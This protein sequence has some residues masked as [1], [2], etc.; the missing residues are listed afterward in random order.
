MRI[1][2]LF[3]AIMQFLNFMPPQQKPAITIAQNAVQITFPKTAAFSV[4]MTSKEKI[5]DVELIYGTDE[6]TCSDVQALVVPEF[7]PGKSVRVSWKWEME[8]S[9][10]IAPG[11]EIWWQWK[12]T[13]EK[14]ETV[15]SEKKTIIWLDKIH[16]WK[17]KE[18][19]NIRIHYYQIT[20]QLA[21]EFLKTALDAQEKLK[22][23][24]G[25]ETTDTVDL[26]MY[27]TNKEMRDSMLYEQEWTGGMAF[28]DSQKIVI[29]I[30]EKNLDWTKT[31]EAHELTHVLVGNYTF[32]CLWTTPTW[33]EEGLAVYAEGEA[34]DSTK[35]EFDKAK[36]N[37][38]LIS[39]HILSASFSSDS[40][41]VGLSYSQSFYMVKYLIDTY[42]RDKINNLLKTLSEGT[43]VDD[44]MKK[45]YGFDLNGFEKEWRK[46]INVPE[47]KW[48]AD[49]EKPTPVPT[50]IPTMQPI[51]NSQ[52][53]AQAT[54][55]AADET[56][57]PT[58]TAEASL[59]IA[60]GS[61]GSGTGT[62]IS[63]DSSN[64]PSSQ[65]PNMAPTILAI[66]GSL[67]ACLVTFI[68]TRSRNRRS[69]VVLT[70]AVLVFASVVMGA[71]PAKASPLT[72]AP[73][74]Y[75]QLPTATLYTPPPAEKGVYLNTTRGISLE[76]PK[77]ARIDTSR[78]SSNYLF[79]IDLS[80]NSVIGHLFVNPLRTGKSLQ[81]MATDIR[82]TE[83]D[84]LI[85]IKHLEDKE[86]EMD[87]GTKGWLMVSEARNPEAIQKL[88]IS[89][90]TVRGF[91]STITLMLFSSRD[92]YDYFQDVI[93]SLN[94]SIKVIAPVINGY[95]RDELLIVD[96]S[97][98]DN[99]AE[100]DPATSRG[101]SGFSNVF[102][103]LVTYDTNLN[104]KP[105][106]AES[107][108]I[109]EDGLV[110]TFHLHPEAVFHNKRPVTADDIVYSW[111]RAANAKT[112][113]ETV[114]TYLGDIQGIKDMHE[115]N[116]EH[117]SGL[118]VIDEHTLEVT[119]DKP[120]PYFLLK[121]TYPT[122]FV[123]DKENVEKSKTWYRLPNGTGPFRLIRWDARQAIY[124]E[125]FE[126]FYG[127]KPK[128]RAIL[129]LLYQGT[130]MQ[131]YEGGVTDYTYIAYDDL[132]RFKDS[133]E[134]MHDQLQSNTNMCTGYI[135]IDV[136]QPPFDDVKVRQAFAMTVD[137]EK[138]INVVT[139]NAVLPAKGLYPPAL[140]GYNK[141][142]KGLE[143]NPEK[144]RALLQE[145]KYGNELPP[146]TFSV[147]GYGNS[148]GE[149]VSALAQMWRE[150]LGVTITV[151]NIDPEYYLDVLD[152]GKHG[153]LISEGWCADYPDPENFADV[154]FHSDNEMNRG[155]YS[156]PELD[157]LL[158]DARVEKDTAKRIQM[159]QQAEEIIINDS[160]VIF[161][162]HSNSYALVKPYLQGFVGT[163]IDVPL[164]RYMWIDAEKFTK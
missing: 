55:P 45:V 14:G 83:L 120:V 158:E 118:K 82:N 97:E 89:F 128:L 17:V 24:T 25:M 105:D 78:A 110:Y 3:A 72:A 77:I 103:G 62:G 139:D 75:P 71:T 164:E 140:P 76:I 123:V 18:D 136:T 88:K 33:L 2:M 30:D 98:T 159:Y 6:R 151:Q 133:S 38:D 127:D 81:E 49:A 4:S 9:G 138:Y 1:L 93:E 148:V 43:T 52:D 114:M 59:P 112:K 37:N 63:L 57:L 60:I 113:S 7:T 92:T 20:D 23:D 94:T 29:G 101:S 67:M 53:A 150:N 36:E 162:T 102:S 51:S 13:N 146:I 104:I 131:L 42:G 143:F 117:I 145:S 68:L 69:G 134:P 58:G 80:N 142:S 152:S 126:E 100:N 64:G 27:K 8:D 66:L 48:A 15:T 129:T 44:A 86:V 157:K 90:L 149:R 61:T 106:L 141:N 28:T 74:K 21:T 91:T 54:E 154:L 135:T 122:S 156:N 26:F 41:T 144:A 130:S 160:P 132:V 34:D 155:N 115:G 84:G 32:T 65:G 119:L 147:S 79:R 40:D 96:G 107:W 108:D 70:L 87:D 109:S 31:T 19:K 11:S 56:P 99:P 35:E 22:T 16:P 73:T 47:A 95:K 161:L 111:E 125:R 5:T 153:Q 46:S 10:S 121:L 124:Y 85:D 163:P 50:Q 12:A 137:K 39:F 116:A